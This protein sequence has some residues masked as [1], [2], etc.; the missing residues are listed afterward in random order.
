MGQ[1]VMN[2]KSITPKTVTINWCTDAA[3]SEALTQL[4]VMNAHTQYISHSELQGS[5]AA[6]PTQWRSDLTATLRAEL[7]ATLAQDP[8]S[9]N[10]LLAT[11]N[12]GD[13]IVGMALVSIDSNPDVATPYAS[14][15][16]L[17][18]HPEHRGNGIGQQLIAWVEQQLLARGIQRLFLES[19]AGNHDAHSFFHGL[20]FQ[21]VSVVMMKELSHA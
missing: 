20:N 7:S 12:I 2:Q 15:D 9:A 5:R 17:I 1:K 3:L 4:F 6:S 16:D 18:V 11:A 19:G 14:L 8:A 10:Q 21:T 13:D